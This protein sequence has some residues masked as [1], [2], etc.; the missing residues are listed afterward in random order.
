MRPMAFAV[1]LFCGLFSGN[2]SF[3]WEPSE[4]LN[5]P[6]LEA[7]ARSISAE[8]RCLVCQ[9]QSID[10][11][12]A[13]LAK[14]LRLLVRERLGAG[15]T[16]SQVFDYLVLR[17]GEFILLQPRLGFNTLALWGAPIL[18]L[19]VGGVALLRGSKKTNQCAVE[20]EL[21][22]EDAA[23]LDQIIERQ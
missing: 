5:D 11:S 17:Y 21:S 20:I 16:D 8:L 12:N 10:D 22:A 1:L 15:D 13:E 2:A 23:R 3:A 4:V 18:L 7:R 19:L 6:N 9:N 14:D